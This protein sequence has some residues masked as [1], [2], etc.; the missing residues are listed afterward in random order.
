MYLF[1]HQKEA[2]FLRQHYTVKLYTRI[3]IRIYIHQQNEV[4]IKMKKSGK[5]RKVLANHM[6]II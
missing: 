2:L 1:V 6:K 4:Q 5:I 3:R